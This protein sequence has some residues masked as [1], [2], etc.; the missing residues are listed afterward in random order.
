MLNS[1]AC[2]LDQ[3]GLTRL[4]TYGL[5]RRLARYLGGVVGLLRDVE[6]DSSGCALSAAKLVLVQKAMLHC[7]LVST[8]AVLPHQCLLEM[9]ERALLQVC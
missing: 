1:S 8:T 7:T 3:D 9:A 2:E 6:V 4:V 5:G